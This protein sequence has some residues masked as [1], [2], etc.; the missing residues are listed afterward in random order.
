M[1]KVIDSFKGLSKFELCLWCSSIL[2][3]VVSFIFLKEKSYLNLVNSLIGATALIFVAKGYVLGQVLTL[4]FSV[5]YGIISYGFAYYGEMITYLGMTAPIAVFSI[6]SWIK[7]PYRDTSEVEVA[8][9]SVKQTAVTV[10]GAAITT[11]IFYFLLDCLD[12]A[13]LI[14]STISITTSFLASYLS[15][16]RS[17]FYALAY[18]ANDVVLIILWILATLENLSYFPMIVCFAVFLVNDIYG[19]FNWRSIY[20]RQ[21][22]ISLGIEKSLL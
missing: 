11:V 16:L 20:K 10:L 18:A 7:H 15:F 5:T 12:N 9:I 2:L 3:I 13:N 4:A 1:K 22:S 17:P 6:I 14:I 19:F 8:K 21:R